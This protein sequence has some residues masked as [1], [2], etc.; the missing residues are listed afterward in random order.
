MM[1]VRVVPASREA[2][3]ADGRTTGRTTRIQNKNSNG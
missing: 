1:D 2:A 3:S